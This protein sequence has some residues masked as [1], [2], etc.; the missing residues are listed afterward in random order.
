MYEKAAENLVIEELNTVI[1]L[2]VE[3]LSKSNELVNKY[4]KQL[5]DI[6]EK[7]NRSTSPK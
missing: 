7:V 2:K 6:E 4:V 3:N 5:N 1:G